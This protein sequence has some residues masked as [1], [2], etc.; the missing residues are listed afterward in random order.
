MGKVEKA[1]GTTAQ[2]L[3]TVGLPLGQQV[4]RHVLER[5]ESGVWPEGFRV[6]SEPRL[7]EEFG[8][9]RMTVHIALRDLAAEGYLIRRQ[10]AGSFVAPRRAQST[11][12]E[13]RNIHTEIEA[14][15]GTHTTDVHAL[16]PLNCDLGVATE[17][18]TAPGAQVFHSLLLHR[19]NGRPLQLEDRYV[20]PQFAPDYLAQD[21]TRITPNEHLMAIGPLEEVEHVIQAIP[22]DARSRALLE[23]DEGDPIL[24]LRRRTWSRGM[25]ATSVRL[26]HPG[27]R[28]SLAGRMAMGR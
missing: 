4:R 27:A 1:A 2:K 15:G 28:F 11:F 5:I 12:L 3:A 23:M 13:L 21:F 9:S 22:G 14:R 18:N 7:A 8:V 26:L 17:L 16:E 19:E 10:G 6:P 24:L 25:I 20:N